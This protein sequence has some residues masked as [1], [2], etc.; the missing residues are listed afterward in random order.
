M[1]K[2]KILNKKKIKKILSML[3]QQFGFKGKLDY[4]FLRSEKNRIYIVNTDLSKIDLEKLNINSL[5][6]YFGTLAENKIRLSIEG[7][8]LIG[9]KSN[10][11]ILDINDAELKTWFRG[12]HVDDGDGLA[13]FVLLKHKDDFV[14]CGKAVQGKI[15]N[16]VSKSRRILTN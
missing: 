4:A 16:Y 3:E 8:Q 15:L 1:K 9:P 2:L 7:S 13:D 12:E 11:N 5:G 10:K 6:L 14:G